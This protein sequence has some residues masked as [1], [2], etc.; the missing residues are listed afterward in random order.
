MLTMNGGFV[1]RPCKKSLLEI[2]DYSGYKI[3]SNNVM[4][5]YVANRLVN[6][7]SIV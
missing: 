2:R 5:F 6:D 3:W 4:H 7:V 1:D